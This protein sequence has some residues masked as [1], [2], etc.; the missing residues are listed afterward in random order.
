MSVQ[1]F[2]IFLQVTI[3]TDF[4]IVVGYNIELHDEM[5]LYENNNI[6]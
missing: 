3:D 5:L 6:W 1:Q 4:S 2:D